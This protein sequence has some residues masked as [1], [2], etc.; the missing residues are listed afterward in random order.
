M[1]CSFVH[2]AVNFTEFVLDIIL[3]MLEAAVECVSSAKYFCFYVC[4]F[5][6]SFVSPHPKPSSRDN[7]ILSGIA[8]KTSEGFLTKVFKAQC[9]T[10]HI[11]TMRV[12][13]CI[14]LAFT[15]TFVLVFFS[16]LSLSFSLE[17]RSV[18]T[19][20][21]IVDWV[22]LNSYLELN[23]HDLPVNILIIK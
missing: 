20:V 22:I 10:C 8:T 19:S 9:H 17:L 2:S 15:V 21:E 11:W 12:F 13:G 16:F 5:I 18:H 1:L 3:K 14:V 23:E 4:F 6:R 7:W